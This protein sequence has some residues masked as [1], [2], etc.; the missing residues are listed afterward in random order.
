MMKTILLFLL[1]LTSIQIAAQDID[2]TPVVRDWDSV[3]D[4]IIQLQRARVNRLAPTAFDLVI[5]DI[6][7]SGNSR[8]NIENLRHSEGGDKLVVA[9]MSIGQAARFQYYWKREWSQ[10]GNW[11]HWADEP[12][13]IWA[14]DVWVHYWESDWQEII[15]SGDDAYLDR[16]INLGFDGVLLDRVDTASYYDEQGRETAY[17]E[18]VDFVIAISEHAKE[19]SPDFGIFTINGEDIPLRLPDSGYMEAVDGLVVES[20]HYGYPRDNEPS[21]KDWTA[22]REA[23]LDQW[24]TAGKLVLT[25]DYSLRPE[26]IDDSYARST[27]RGYVP[28]VS[29]RSLGRTLIHKGHEPD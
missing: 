21:Y 10:D 3:N 27:E 7:L 12:D 5:A 26:H 16:I 6:S 2:S 14:G 20:L 9:Y 4:Y 8:E 22:L 19:R 28:Y 13:G 17:Q 23:D 11:P 24:V 1:I 29:V 18:M 25:V 15:L